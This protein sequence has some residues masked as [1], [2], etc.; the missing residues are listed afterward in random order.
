MQILDPQNLMLKIV[1]AHFTTKFE[2]ILFKVI[3][4]SLSTAILYV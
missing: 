3:L 1:S 2:Q 4:L